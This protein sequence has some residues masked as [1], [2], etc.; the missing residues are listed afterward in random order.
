MVA[1][2]ELCI[3]RQQTQEKAAK[4]K[5]RGN[6]EELIV[7]DELRIKNMEKGAW[8]LKDLVEEDHRRDDGISRSFTVKLDDER[9]ARKNTS[10]IHH[11]MLALSSVPH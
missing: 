5:G 4:A 9:M 6:R 11:F 10:Y 7:S 1:R 8:D 2:R 3:K